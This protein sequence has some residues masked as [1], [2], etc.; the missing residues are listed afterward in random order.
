[1]TV[2]MI[3]VFIIILVL[4]PYARV[5]VLHPINVVK[6]IPPDLYTYFRW[7]R[8]NKVDMGKLVAITGYFGAGKTLTGVHLARKFAKRWENKKYFDG[9]HWITQHV[10]ILSN[11]T[12]QLKKGTFIYMEGL[13]DIV[14][15]AEHY[16]KTDKE[17]HTRT[18]IFV[19][20]DEFGSNMNSRNFKSN[21]DMDFLSTMLCCRHYSMSIYYIAQKF[22]LVDKLLRDVTQ[23]VYYV[24]KLWRLCYYDIL[25]A[26]ELENAI[27]PEVIK[28]RGR[29]GYFATNGL[30]NSYDTI[31]MAD[32]MSHDCKEGNRLTVS[33]IMENRGYVFGGMDAVKNPK[34]S[35]RKKH[36]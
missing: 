10:I 17:N 19:L 23:D 27:N 29:H 7:K 24:H 35:W 25:D 5:V 34:R 9:K 11:V 3:I 21:I 28:I 31:A 2:I 18:L 15:L 33:E 16:L 22:N 4:V 14:A 12:I 30:F 36:K 6:Y 13:S 20:G 32:R 1:M 8:Y 26:T